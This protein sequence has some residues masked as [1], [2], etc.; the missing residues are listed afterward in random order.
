MEELVL[1]CLDELEKPHWGHIGYQFGVT[2]Q[3]NSYGDIDVCNG[4]KC[5]IWHMDD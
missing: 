5:Y 3:C 4:H 1:I 2:N